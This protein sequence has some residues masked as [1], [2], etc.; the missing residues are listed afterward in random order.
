MDAFS[1]PQAFCFVGAL[2]PTVGT[3]VDITT[4]FT[5][6][7]RM[8]LGMDFSTPFTVHCPMNLGRDVSM[9]APDKKPRM[10]LRYP[11]PFL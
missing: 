2:L 3:T 5:I 1:E 8:N 7:Y 9:L 11:R 6:R 10:P 4:P